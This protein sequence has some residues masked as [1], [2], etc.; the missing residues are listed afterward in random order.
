MGCKE[1]AQR[2]FQEAARTA[3]HKEDKRVANA[4]LALVLLD[5]DPED[6][7]SEANVLQA[8][9]ILEEN[10]LWIKSETDTD[11]NLRER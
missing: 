9:T 11:T 7:K 5:T 8:A 6:Q 10:E 3:Q 4:E 1:E 2:H